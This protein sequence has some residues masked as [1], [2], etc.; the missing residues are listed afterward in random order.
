[1]SGRRI[2]LSATQVA[3]SVLAAVT[4][5]IVASSLGVTGTVVGVAVVSFASTAGTAIY[6]HYLARTRER[7][8]L[9]QQ[10]LHAAAARGSR[11]GAAAMGPPGDAGGRARAPAARG[12]RNPA[13]LELL[14]GLREAQPGTPPP[15]TDRTWVMPPDGDRP[16]PGR[17][18][19]TRNGATRAGGT[20]TGGTHPGGARAGSGAGGPAGAAGWLPRARWARYAGLAVLVFALA[21]AGVTVVETVTGKPLDA[22]IW[23]AHTSGTTVGNVVGDPPHRPRPATRHPG[24]SPPHHPSSR[25]TPQA[26]HPV[27][28]SATPTSTAPPSRSPSPSA[29]PSP[30]PSGSTPGVTGKL[31]A[32]SVVRQARHVR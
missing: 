10:R 4:G 32:P 23:G 16:H 18:D 25:S 2:E 17:S 29:T 5:A 8:R 9:A 13:G 7:F 26:S 27:T 28:P 30:S 3:A 19:G 24:G 31:T 15:P 11:P 1:M 12:G 21:M 14:R 20:D 22:L 6:R